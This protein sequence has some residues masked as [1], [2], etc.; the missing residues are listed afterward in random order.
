MSKGKN[1]LENLAYIHYY[2]EVQNWSCF[3]IYAWNVLRGSL[4]GETFIIVLSAKITVHVCFEFTHG[5][6]CYLQANIPIENYDSHVS[7][8]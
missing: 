7:I 5:A 6:K 1:G 8:L 3:L 2:F 4:G